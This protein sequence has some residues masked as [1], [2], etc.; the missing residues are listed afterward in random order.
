MSDVTTKVSFKVVLGKSTCYLGNLEELSAELDDVLVEDVD[1]KIK[2]GFQGTVA[3]INAV[4]AKV[5]ETAMEC[6][7]KEIVVDLPGGWPGLL[8]SG[9]LQAAGI[10][11]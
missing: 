8:I 10:K 5:K 11:L 2:L 4:W 3:V 9:A 6:E 1:G 7:G